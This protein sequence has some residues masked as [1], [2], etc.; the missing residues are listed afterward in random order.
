MDETND[1]SREISLD[2][3][4]RLEASTVELG[5]VFET[6]E[7][8]EPD[9]FK[10][11]PAYTPGHASAP[12]YRERADE[13]RHMLVTNRCLAMLYVDA[14]NL[15]QIE[16]DYGA[17]IYEQVRNILANLIL[18]MRGVETR[19]DDLITVNENMATPS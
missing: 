16:H 9:A 4:E 19:R 10:R 1:A 13:I 8:V 5:N 17:G 15:A 6:A 18:D 3:E 2:A 14:S 12:C 11:L 7:R